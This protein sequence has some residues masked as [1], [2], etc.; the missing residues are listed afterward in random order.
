MITQRFSPG[1]QILWRDETFEIDRLLPDNQVQLENVLSGGMLTAKMNELY[2]DLFD[3]HLEFVMMGKGTKKQNDCKPAT[4]VEYLSLADC[5]PK[6]LEQAKFRLEAIRPLLDSKRTRQNVAARSMEISGS[7]KC[8]YLSS[9]LATLYRWLKYYEQSGR[10]L[11]SL[12]PDMDSRGGRGDTRTDESVEKIISDVI[13]E[14]FGSTTSG[15]GVKKTISDLHLEI[16]RRID[17]ENKHRFANEKL[18]FPCFMTIQRRIDALDI[19]DRL[20]VRLGSRAAK[21]QL[22]QYGKGP[23]AERPGER[24]EIDHTKLDLI[25][26]DESDNLPLG[27]LTVTDCLDVCTRYVMGFYIGF[28]PPSYYTVMECLYNAILPKIGLRE[29][30]NLEHDWIAC[31]IPAALATDNGK[32]FIGNSLGD[33]CLDLDILL[34]QMPIKKPH[35]KGKIERLFRSVTFLVHGLPGTTF[36]NVRERGEYDSEGQA[37]LYLSDAKEILTKYFVDYYGERLHKGIR[38]IPARRWEAHFQQ[39]FTPRVPASAEKLRILL[40]RSFSRTIQHYGI[41]FENILYNSPDLGDLR[42]RLEGKDVKIKIHPGD[43]SRIYIYNPFEKSYFEIPAVDPTGYTL[44]LSLWKHRVIQRY[45][46]NNQDKVDLAA[47]G[48][49][50]AAIQRIVDAARERKR[51]TSRS[52]IKRWESDGSSPSLMDQAHNSS[53]VLPVA[54]ALASEPLSEQAVENHNIE[55]SDVAGYEYEFIGRSN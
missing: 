47:L 35:F 49:A 9:S 19:R 45:I 16:C 37:C 12:I 52:K 10:D 43:I 15:P 23:E 20:A 26:I 44:N 34:D 18:T 21:K 42:H 36:S 4:E 31:G 38:A 25:V 7:S 30:Y 39:G 32:E 53:P 28:E 29:K 17:D 3:G 8:G 2:F 14:Y 5:P 41:S 13:N 6:M 51:V 40:G 27:R 48:R 11:R 24:M 54:P 1:K 55:L 50:K 46:L 22:E 33:A